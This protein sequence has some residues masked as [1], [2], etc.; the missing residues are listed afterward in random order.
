MIEPEYNN[1]DS[2]ST[3]KTR[4]LSLPAAIGRLA[5]SDTR[6]RIAKPEGL[7]DLWLFIAI[8]G[9]DGC[10]G[11]RSREAL[12]IWLV[13]VVVGECWDPLPRK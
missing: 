12:E 2:P 11:C 7:G 6:R 8:L 4:R 13:G 10:E 1:L 9:G 5:L 3:E